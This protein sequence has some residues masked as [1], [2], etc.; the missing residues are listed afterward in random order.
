MTIGVSG[1]SMSQQFV[2]S[3]MGLSR[4]SVE[5]HE[6]FLVPKVWEGKPQHWMKLRIPLCP[7]DG[8]NNVTLVYQR[9]D[10]YE[11]KEQDRDALTALIEESDYLILNWGVHYQPWAEME[12]ATDDFVRVLEK[13]WVPPNKKSERLFWRSTN[14]AHANCSIATG[15]LHDRGSSIN[16]GSIVHEQYNTQ[17][18]LLQDEYIV[19]PRLLG[20]LPHTTLL[21][22]EETTIKRPDG[23]RVEGFQGQEDCLHYCEPGPIDHWAELFYHHVVALEI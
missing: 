3:L 22:V 11:G 2:H 13:L 20:S 16:A 4:G 19:K 12:S 10:K 7:D 8:H 6:N 5:N 9:W 15:P 17:E 1:D 18:I 21:R 14:V 23:H